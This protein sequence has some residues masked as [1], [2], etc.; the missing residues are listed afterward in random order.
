MF[1]LDAMAQAEDWKP[2]SISSALSLSLLLPQLPLSPFSPRS[3]PQIIRLKVDLPDKIN[4]KKL[5]VKNLQFG[6]QLL[7][8]VSNTNLKIL[9]KFS[10]KKIKIITYNFTVVNPDH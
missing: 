2:C 3:P 6:L 9:R 1:L 7:I 10:E 5:K 8:E 4:W